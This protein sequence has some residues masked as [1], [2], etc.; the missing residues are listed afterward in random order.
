LPG[1]ESSTRT[2]TPSWGATPTSTGRPSAPPSAGTGAR[3]CASWPSAWSWKPGDTC[4]TCR[5]GPTC[6]QCCQRGWISM[7]YV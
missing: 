7:R 2:S 4:V 5:D 3:A 6:P 1:R